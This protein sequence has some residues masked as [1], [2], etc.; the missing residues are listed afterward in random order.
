VLRGPIEV[1]L[2]GSVDEL[3][4]RPA[5]RYAYEVKLDGWLN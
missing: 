3:P 1:M 2:A 4:I 5:G